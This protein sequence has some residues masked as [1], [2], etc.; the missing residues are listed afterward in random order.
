MNKSALI[1]SAVEKFGGSDSARLIMSGE[2]LLVS[3]PRLVFKRVYSELRDQGW[4]L[5]EDTVRTPSPR[6]IELAPFFREG[7]EPGMTDGEELVRRARN[8]GINHGQEDM[9]WLLKKEREIPAKF[10]KFRL[11]FP[12]TIWEDNLGHRRIAVLAYT[13]HNKRWAMS[14]DYLENKCRKFTRLVRFIDGKQKN[15][16]PRLSRGRNFLKKPDLSRMEM[17]FL[18]RMFGGA[19]GL[20]RT[21]DEEF[22]IVGNSCFDPEGAGQFI[23]SISPLRIDSQPLEL[24]SPFDKGEN[25]GSVSGEEILR[26]SRQLGRS[27]LGR[28]DALWL[29]KN[30]A[31]GILAEYQLQYQIA[32]PADTFIDRQGYRKMPAIIWSSGQKWFWSPIYLCQKV[33]AA[34]RLAVASSDEI[35]R[36]HV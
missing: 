22:V 16:A 6:A 10:R 35:G 29:L 2:L 31:D 21:L 14:W 5:K 12:G 8:R 13:Q 17:D 1:K 20:S 15:H 33:S 26:R 4:R 27:Y 34:L 23:E 11:A 32:F 19:D 18:I 24:V 3:V 7:E 28:K 9:L 25:S 36:A 30:Q